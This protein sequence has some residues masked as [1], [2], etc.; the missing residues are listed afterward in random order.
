MPSGRYLT[1]QVPCDDNECH[2]NIDVYPLSADRSVSQGLCGNF[3]DTAPNDLTQGGL[4]S[5]LHPE[6]PIKFSKYFLSVFQ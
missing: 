4:P 6:E 3:D 5:S 2:M 1:A